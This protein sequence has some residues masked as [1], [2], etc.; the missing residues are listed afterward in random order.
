MDRE[1]V[2][3]FPVP[4]RAREDGLTRQIRPSHPAT[5]C[6]FSTPKLNLVLLSFLP[7]SATVSIH[8]ENRHRVSFEFIGSCIRI[9]IALIAKSPPTQGAST[10]SPQD[11]SSKGCCLLRKPDGP[12]FGRPSFST[13]T[14]GTV[15]MRVSHE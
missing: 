10:S 15:G 9:T 3:F 2:F 13:P 12:I 6:S 8:T 5:V 14:F 4:D 11:G 1:N 7:L